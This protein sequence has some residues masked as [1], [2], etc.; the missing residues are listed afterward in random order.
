M[1][2]PRKLEIVKELSGT[3]RKNPNRRPPPSAKE[4]SSGLGDPPSDWIEAAKH[5][6]R[7]VELLKTW[8]QIVDQD[9]LRV[10]NISHRQLVK[11]FC[12]LQYKVDRAV[13]GYGKMTSGDFAQLRAYGAEIGQTPLSSPRVADAVRVPD[14]PGAATQG[15]RPGAGWGELVG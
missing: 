10:L 11:N 7:F 13:A 6:Q 8:R 1:G 4:V 12:G 14:R 5:N 9:V 3:Y 2:R 15:A